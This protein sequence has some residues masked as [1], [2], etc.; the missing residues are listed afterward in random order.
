MIH[1]CKYTCRT[2]KLL[3]A[4]CQLYSVCIYTYSWNITRILREFWPKSRGSLCICYTTHIYVYKYRSE[5][6]WQIYS[7]YS[8]L[9]NVQPF[10]IVVMNKSILRKYLRQD[11]ANHSILYTHNALVYITQ[12]KQNIIRKPII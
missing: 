11:F 6:C 4:L 10:V 2:H 1:V 9:N 8:L 12:H 5:I 3:F 7:N